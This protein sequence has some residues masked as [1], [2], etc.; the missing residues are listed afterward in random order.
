M[1]TG[2]ALTTQNEKSLSQPS[3]VAYVVRPN[4]KISVFRVT[5]LKTLG[6]VGIHIYFFWKINNFMHFERHFAFQ[7]A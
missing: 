4:K 6:R 3:Q 1:S 2:K 7:N 5:G